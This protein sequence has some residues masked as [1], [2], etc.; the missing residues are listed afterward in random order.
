MNKLYAAISIFSVALATNAIAQHDPGGKLV[1][2][3]ADQAC[4][5]LKDANT[6]TTYASDVSGVGS[7]HNL[8]YMLTT[9]N[10][11]SVELTSSNHPPVIGYGGGIRWDDADMGS[12]AWIPQG[13]THGQSGTTPFAI[14]AWHWNTNAFSYD[15]G[16]RISIVDTTDLSNAKYRNVML[17]EPTGSGTYQP[18]KSHVGGLAIAG[19]YLYVADEGSETDGKFRVF[20]LNNF[21]DTYNSGATCQNADG[22]GK[23]GLVS[24]HW[25]ADAYAYMLPQVSSYTI[26]S[27]KSDGTTI[28]AACKPHFSWAGNDIRQSTNYIISGEYCD[29]TT[30]YMCNGDSSG[31]NGRLYQWTLGSDNKLVTSSLY[32]TPHKVYYVNEFKVQGVA[33]DYVRGAATDRY[34]LSSTQYNGRLFKVSPT[35]DAIIWGYPNSQVPYHPEGMF[36]TTN[37]T[38]LWMDTEGDGGTTTNPTTKGRVLIF[39][40]QSAV[41]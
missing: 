7:A 31:T 32:V 34:W 30:K 39:I 23:F 21:R 18:V 40:N 3:A 13:M 27:T 33:A 1:N 28:P 11:S 6:W 12:N 15:N 24:G 41:N 26:P 19:N 14:V 8:A 17:V 25:C 10:N 5:Q 9:L 20:D 38:H 2:D 4:L 29:D 35:A 37:G 22:S 36:G 16:A